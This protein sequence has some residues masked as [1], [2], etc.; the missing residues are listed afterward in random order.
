MSLDPGGSA[1]SQFEN[2]GSALFQ[3][4]RFFTGLDHRSV[5]NQ[6]CDELLTV[7]AHPLTTICLPARVISR[8]SPATRS[9]S[10]VPSHSPLLQG[11]KEPADH[12]VQATTPRDE[13]NRCSH[14]LRPINP[15][16]TNLSLFRSCASLQRDKRVQLTT[17]ARTPSSAGRVAGLYHLFDSLQRAKI[18]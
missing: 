8:Q 13:V 14:R 10:L 15:A 18:Y 7:P 5:P 12:R 1:P 9:L 16:S 6:V 3:F 17:L 4:D 2:G 11:E